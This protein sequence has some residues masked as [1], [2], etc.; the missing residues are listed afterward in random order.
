MSLI[1]LNINDILIIGGSMTKVKKQSKAEKTNKENNSKEKSSNEKSKV[2][3]SKKLLVFAIVS[4]S[5]VAIAITLLLLFSSNKSKCPDD[6][7]LL[8]DRCTKIETV[9]PKQINI[10]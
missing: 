8:D 10:V 4:V 3:R 9:E 1:L 6:Y 2:K 5:I 7:K